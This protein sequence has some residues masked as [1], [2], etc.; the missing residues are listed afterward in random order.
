MSLLR[1]TLLPISPVEANK[2]ELYVKDLTITATDIFIKD[3]GGEYVVSES[4]GVTAAISHDALFA[5]GTA[6]LSL[7]DLKDP[8]PDIR[9]K[10]WRPDGN[11]EDR[12]I[13]QKDIQYHT[14][15]G[16]PSDVY[17]FLSDPS[18]DNELAALVGTSGASETVGGAMPFTEIE[19]AA[20]ESI[21]NEVEGVSDDKGASAWLVDLKID[22]VDDF[23]ALKHIA[24]II[25]ASSEKMPARPTNI[26]ALYT[27]PDDDKK[28]ADR[29]AFEQAL[30]QTENRRGASV[31]STIKELKALRYAYVFAARSEKTLAAKEPNAD[32]VG[33]R[34]PLF[35]EQKPGKLPEIA[36][37][38][39]KS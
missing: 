33:W 7:D 12:V 9:L 21:K 30:Q 8:T 17:L 23:A 1:I 14:R 6:T 13:V 15:A 25:V 28:K 5:F 16:D 31:D 19:A 38:L 18:M 3:D 36:I 11:G 26:A 29:G 32:N 2:F 34:V 10:V 20:R 24:N 22:T 35:A 39:K 4:D 37:N 27:A